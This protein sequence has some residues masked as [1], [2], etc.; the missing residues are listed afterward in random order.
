MSR[1]VHSSEVNLEPEA[2]AEIAP[3]V[4]GVQR[5]GILSE[6]VRRALSEAM[7]G[8]PERDRELVTLRYF[9]G[10][11]IKELSESMRMP[12]GSVGTTISR[13]LVRVRATLEARGI[14]LGDLLP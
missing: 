10:L 9:A 2:I 5:A 6:Q 13:A 12:M 11:S 4:A 14:S 8:L 7:N 1:R 3:G